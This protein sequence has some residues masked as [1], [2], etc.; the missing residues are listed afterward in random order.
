M[1]GKIGQ[2]TYCFSRIKIFWVASIVVICC[3]VSAWNVLSS[4]H[5]FSNVI[6]LG[7]LEH[8]SFML[9][10]VRMRWMKM[11]QDIVLSQG[12]YLKWEYHCSEFDW[13]ENNCEGDSTKFLVSKSLLTQFWKVRWA[14]SKYNKK[15]SQSKTIL[16]KTSTIPQSPGHTAG[17]KMQPHFSWRIACSVPS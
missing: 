6:I 16:R 1:T 17:L 3:P 13:R 4:L 15:L 12:N 11:P 9:Q 14:M 2:E 10:S 8:Y 5:L 7:K